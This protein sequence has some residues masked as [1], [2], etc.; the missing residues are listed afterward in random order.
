VAGST[1]AQRNISPVAD[2]RGERCDREGHQHDCDKANI[3]HVGS[4][5]KFGVVD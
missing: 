5:L 3:F 2:I 1:L 4:T